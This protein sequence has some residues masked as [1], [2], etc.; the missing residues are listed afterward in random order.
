M[1]SMGYDDWWSR[2][3]QDLSD[4]DRIWICACLLKSHGVTM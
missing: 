4:G 1:S 2:I 3:E